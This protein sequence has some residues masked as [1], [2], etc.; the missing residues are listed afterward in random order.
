[1][2]IMICPVCGEIA[3]YNSHFGTIV[4]RACGW[5]RD[6]KPTNADRIR[7]M[8]DEE[9]AK[10][11]VGIKDC[12]EDCPIGVMEMRCHTICDTPEHLMDWLIQPAKEE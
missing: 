1:M 2:P 7:A 5:A 6:P 9:L 12:N 3:A 8:S 4:C 10:M 11:I